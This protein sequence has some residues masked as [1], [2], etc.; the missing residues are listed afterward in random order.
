MA[1]LVIVNV[2]I[3][4]TED[5]NLIANT[6]SS[7]EIPCL[8]EFTKLGFRQI[9]D[10][11]ETS[12]IDTSKNAIIGAIENLFSFLATKLVTRAQQAQQ[13][14]RP[15]ESSEIVAARNPYIVE[16]EIGQ[17]KIRSKKLVSGNTILSVKRIF[18]FHPE[19]RMSLISS[20]D[21]TCRPF[22]GCRQNNE[23]F[24]SF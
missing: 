18:H 4:D 9:F 24:G 6:S 8:D 16:A 13:Q 14:L 19:I 17:L 5:G 7:T 12:A 2:K 1:T 3:I 22:Y 15:E 23:K 10:K 20:G 21:V 11:V